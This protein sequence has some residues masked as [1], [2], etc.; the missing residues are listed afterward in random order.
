[1]AELADTSGDLPLVPA[2]KR[3]D[4]VWCEQAQ[5]YVIVGSGGTEGVAL[6]LSQT[7]YSYQLK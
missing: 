1:M 3:N 5:E 7:V 4:K 2:S 6:K